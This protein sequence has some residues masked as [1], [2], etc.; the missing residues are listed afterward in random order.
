MDVTHFLYHLTGDGHLSYF[1]FLA[2][3]NSCHEHLLIRLCADMCAFALDIYLAVEE[4]GQV[5]GVLLAFTTLPT[6]F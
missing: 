6:L 1:Y 3:I 4:V 2:P 5:G